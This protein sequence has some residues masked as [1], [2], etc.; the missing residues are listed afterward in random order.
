VA[1]V[2]WLWVTAVVAGAMAVV[3]RV[4]ER[5]APRWAVA[6]GPRRLLPFAPPLAV[7]WLCAVVFA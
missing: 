7:G 6:A 5:R 2:V 1:L 4:V 3:R